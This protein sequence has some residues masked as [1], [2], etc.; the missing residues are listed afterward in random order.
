MTT[1]CNQQ[2]PVQAA[3]TEDTAQT[4]DYPKMITARMYIKP[5]REDDFIT[6]A[7]TMID[8][9]KAEEGCLSYMLYQEPYEKTNFIFIER[10]KNQAA[11]DFHFGTTY[12]KAFGEKTADMTS[13]PAD[14][15]ILD[16]AGE[17]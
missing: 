1:S 3:K 4:V 15:K 5:G 9:V 8:S 6:A 11:I 14:V 16:I 10:Y 12:F 17:K 13:K 2:P 7:K